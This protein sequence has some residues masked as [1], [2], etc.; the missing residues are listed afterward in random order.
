MIRQTTELINLTII[1][2]ITHVGN[3]NDCQLAIGVRVSVTLVI[4]NKNNV[5]CDLVTPVL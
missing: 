4:G 2:I 1:I 3:L 5:V